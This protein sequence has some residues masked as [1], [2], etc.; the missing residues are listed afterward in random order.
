MKAW[1]LL[2]AVVVVLAAGR[3]GSAQTYSLAE[4]VQTGDCFRIRIDMVLAGEMQIKRSGGNATIKMEATA[5]HDFPER[6]LAVTPKGV[7]EKVAR[8]YKEARTTTTIDRNRGERSL[9]A[10]RTLIVAQRHEDHPL[11]YCPNGTLTR[12]ELALTSEHFDTL[13]LTGLLPAQQVAVGDTWKVPSAVVEALCSF[14]GLTGHDLVCKLEEVKDQVA[15]VSVTGSAT[16]IDL[17][18]LAKLTIQATYRVDLKSQRLTQLEWKQKDERDQ[19][20]ASPAQTLEVTTT[21]TR[22]VID[23]PLELGDI[24]LV[25]VPED[26]VPPMHLLQLEHRDSKNRF[27]MLYAR[28]WQ[29]VAQDDQHLVLRLMD[30]G[31]LVAQ[32]TITPWTQAGKG[33]HMSAEEFAQEMARTP[34]WESEQELQ[35]GEVPTVGGRWVYRISALGQLDGTKVMQNFYLVAGPGGEQVVVVFTLTPKQA[36]RLGDR[37]L[38]MAASIDFPK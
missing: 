3:T 33:K 31:D 19:G 13:A 2:G 4:T 9:R 26:F 30:Q 6:V 8:V 16:G 36:T 11:V 15:R 17:G 32:A 12:D 1:R 29:T 38:S 34:G 35:A 25:S 5:A 18:A 22:T 21:L 14:E 24:A 7:P 10:D 20:P 37:D 27:T 23:Q 28:Q